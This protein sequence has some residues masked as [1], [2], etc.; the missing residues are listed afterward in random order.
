MLGI[1]AM[2][3]D[4]EIDPGSK[5]VASD[6]TSALAIGAGT[7]SWRT[8]HLRLKAGWIQ[9][10]R[11]R[12]E[13]ATQH[14]PGI[15]QPADLLTKPLS[16]QRIRDLLHLWGLEDSA[17]PLSRAVSTSS[18]S[19]TRMLVAMVCCL[20]MLTVEARDATPTR[21]IEVDWDLAAVFMGLMMIMGALMFYEGIK[22]GL[23]EIY[24]QYTPGASSRRMR[25]LKKLREA[26]TAAIETELERT[27]HELSTELR[28]D[29]GHQQQTTRQS[30][31]G[32][33]GQSAAARKR[34]Y[35]IL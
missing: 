27:T 24:Y 21:T 19:T 30:G 4:L 15:H 13:V 14:Q 9:E 18:I 5:V 2:I 7:G 17:R 26:T 25:R 32:Q 11:N 22:W 12:G 10:M 28:R 31:T 35:S 33:A 29:D 20:M 8:R 16:A 3:M 23:F 6:S 34:R 1:E